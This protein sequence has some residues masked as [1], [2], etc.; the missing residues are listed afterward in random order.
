MKKEIKKKPTKYDTK[1]GNWWCM[2]NAWKIPKEIRCI[3]RKNKDFAHGAFNLLEAIMTE[4]AWTEADRIW[5]KKY[6]K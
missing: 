4:E 2:L 3:D 1:L 6:G 5:E